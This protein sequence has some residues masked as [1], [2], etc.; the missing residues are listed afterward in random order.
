M[1]YCELFIFRSQFQHHIQHNCLSL[2]K[3]C[4]MKIKIKNAAQRSNTRTHTQKRRHQ[5][6]T[7]QKLNTQDNAFIG[8]RKETTERKKKIIKETE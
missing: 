5:H 7:K 3:K 2:M 8:K 6:K 4:K 1:R